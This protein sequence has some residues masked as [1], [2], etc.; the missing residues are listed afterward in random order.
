MEKWGEF[1]FNEPYND[2][3]ILKINWSYYYRFEWS[4]RTL[5]NR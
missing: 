3:D 4:R 5:W 2:A 1:E